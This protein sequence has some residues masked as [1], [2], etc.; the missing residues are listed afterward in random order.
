MND[1]INQNI[2]EEYIDF[3]DKYKVKCSITQNN[4]KLNNFINKNEFK[5]QDNFYENGNSG[6]NIYDLFKQNEKNKLIKI[7]EN[8]KQELI[9]FLNSKINALNNNKFNFSSL[10]KSILESENGNNI[11]KKKIKREIMKIQNNKEEFEIKYL[12]I[13]IVGK[14][15][16]GKSTLINNLLKLDKDH[17][18]ETGTGNFVST[19]TRSYQSSSMPFLKLVDTRGIELNVGYGPEQVK[20]E[21]IKYINEQYKTNDPNNYVQCIWYCITGNRFENP[22]VELLNSLRNAYGD[23]Q[24]PIIIVYTQATD[25]NAINEMENY[26]KEHNIDA[27]FLMVLA[28]EKKLTNGKSLSPKGLNELVYITLDKCRKALKGE[29]RSVILKNIS[30][31]IVRKIKTE[32]SY[33]RNYILEKNILDLINNYLIL[34]E[35]DD[36]IK[37]LINIF[38][39]NILFFLNKP[40]SNENYNHFFNSD[41]IQ[42]K[43]QKY[44]LDYKNNAKKLIE[45][46][47]EDL[48]IEFLD[49]QV[50]IQKENKKSISLNNKRRLEE[51]KET[52]KNF[53][54]GNFYFIS[55]IK[56]IGNFIFK[57]MENLSKIFE[58]SLN[59][60]TEN[61]INDTEPQQLI[62]QCFLMK[63]AEFEKKLSTQN[64]L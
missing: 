61:L 54:N 8:K 55:Q 64:L 33:I 48:A 7:I 30:S 44:I 40:M 10:V 12:T 35:D 9:E 21:A 2:N 63:F 3:K 18:A 56:L 32:N 20:K 60:S 62:D 26:I 36:F 53:L 49:D 4:T 43:V 31:N 17:K 38:G 39:D 45:P 5:I 25:K 41:I 14:S 47:L 42:N 28:E 23:N 1:S 11:Y 19:E 29:M 15:G 50:K 52:T 6:D 37:H 24:I 13:M 27:K 57:Q 22:E 46:N 34:K 16:V 51:F 59:N 58:N